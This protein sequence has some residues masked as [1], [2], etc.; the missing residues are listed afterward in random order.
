MEDPLLLR[1]PEP[2]GLQR[3]L[4]G[5]VSA[6]LAGMDCQNLANLLSGLR[7][8]AVPWSSS[9]KNE[10]RRNRN[11]GE[12]GPGLGLGFVKVEALP[13]SIQRA[14]IAAVSKKLAIAE[15]LL[16]EEDIVDNPR[17]SQKKKEMKKEQQSGSRDRFS[18]AGLVALCLTFEALHLQKD[19]PLVAVDSWQG[20]GGGAESHRGFPATSAVVEQLLRAVGASSGQFSE[21]ERPVVARCLGRLGWLSLLADSD[22]HAL[23]VG[24]TT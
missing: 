13:G 22:R 6:Q 21:L 24:G 17:H 4:L 3:S 20:A 10:S 8:M 15:E 2:C 23:F 14:L 18:P 11:H 9:R 12:E 5:Q 16:N 19:P 7:H 1:P